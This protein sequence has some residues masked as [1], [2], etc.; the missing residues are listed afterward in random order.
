MTEEL[1]VASPRPPEMLARSIHFR[2]KEQAGQALLVSARALTREQMMNRFEDVSI[3]ARMLY[4]RCKFLTSR[5][6]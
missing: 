6:S 2:E 3:N 5:K 4:F 1:R